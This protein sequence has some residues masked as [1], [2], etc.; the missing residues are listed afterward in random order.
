MREDLRTFVD[1][2][3]DAAEAALLRPNVKKGCER[4]GVIWGRLEDVLNNLDMRPPGDSDPKK[5]RRFSISGEW[6]TR[7]KFLDIWTAHES[8][9][10]ERGEK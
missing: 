9:K 3:Q 10:V 4:S 2:I 8:R 6:I 5:T 7:A 1:Q